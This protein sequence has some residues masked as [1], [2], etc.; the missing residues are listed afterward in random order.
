[1]NED[2]IKAIKECL[3]HT[4]ILAHITSFEFDKSEAEGKWFWKLK[5]GVKES[6][7]HLIEHLKSVSLEIG[8]LNG[9]YLWMKSNG[10]WLW[11]S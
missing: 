2:T 9:E 7:V 1:M 8:K 11:L 10:R 6:H 4:V 3:N 5:I